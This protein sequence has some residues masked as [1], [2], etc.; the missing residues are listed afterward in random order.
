MLAIATELTLFL[1]LKGIGR[2]ALTSEAQQHC[3]DHW[4]KEVMKN[5]DAGHT[6]SYPAQ[7]WLFDLHYVSIPHVNYLHSP[8]IAVCCGE[9]RYVARDALRQIFRRLYM[10]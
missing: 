3:C 2:E 7:H 1:T 6:N 10:P 8:T 9:K 5:A 4:T